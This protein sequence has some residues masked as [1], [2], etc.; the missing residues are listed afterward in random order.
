RRRQELI[1]QSGRARTCHEKGRVEKAVG[2]VQY[3]VAELEGVPVA[4]AGEAVVEYEGIARVRAAQ[5]NAGLIHP[6]SHV[7]ISRHLSITIDHLLVNDRTNALLALLIV[8][9]IDIP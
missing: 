1:A 2:A 6:E 5:L 9:I 8:L 3:W 4:R 7:G